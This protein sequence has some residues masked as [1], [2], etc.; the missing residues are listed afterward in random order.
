[1]NLKPE[2]RISAL[3]KRVTSLEGAIE[4]LSSDQ[5]EGLKMVR[6]EIKKLDDGMTSSFKKFGDII[7]DTL[8]TKDDLTAMA[9]KDDLASLESRLDRFESTMAT[10]DDIERLIN[11]I[12]G[13]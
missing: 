12:R 9:T 7:I 6:Q 3:E 1:M 13:K 11:V 4:E 5:A 10:K 2:Y 8:A